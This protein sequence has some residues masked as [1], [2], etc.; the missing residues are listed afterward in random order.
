MLSIDQNHIDSEF[1]GGF[2]T[3]GDSELINLRPSSGQTLLNAHQLQTQ[4][5]QQTKSP[6][7]TVTTKT[8]NSTLPQSNSNRDKKSVMLNFK[9][10]GKINSTVEEFGNFSTRFSDTFT[11]NG[12]RYRSWLLA[13]GITISCLC[14]FVFGLSFNYLFDTQPCGGKLVYFMI[15]ITV[16][17]SAS[18]LEWMSEIECVYIYICFC[19]YGRNTIIFFFSFW[20]IPLKWRFYTCVYH[21][22][23]S[24]SYMFV[25]FFLL[26]ESLHKL[27]CL[28]IYVGKK[29][30]SFTMWHRMNEWERM[31]SS[32]ILL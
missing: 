21:H 4:Q 6:S 30:F 18:L 9:S 2:S 29:V 22:F 31:C 14:C 15:F 27:K 1:N 24:V 28:F 32:F 7:A 25:V 13:I 17:I 16:N 8:Q 5:Q 12:H 20:L 23:F 11:Q 19:E 3:I 10:G 26:N